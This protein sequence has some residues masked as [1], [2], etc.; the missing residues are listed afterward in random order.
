M[1]IEMVLNDLSVP[2]PMQDRAAAR[3]L[4]HKLIDVLSEAGRSGLNV[5][6]TKEALYPVELSPEYPIS[7]WLNDSEVEREKRSFL[8]SLVTKTP[9]L[10]EITD[11]SIQDQDI[12]AEF[13]YEGERAYGLGIAYL[14]NALAVSFAS[15]PKWNCNRLEITCDELDSE[16]SAL[17]EILTS[18]KTLIHASCR[19]HVLSHKDLFQDRLRTF[20]WS[21][22]DDLLPC[23]IA[24]DQKTPLVEWLDSLSA[25]TKQ[26]IQARL[27]QVK[28]GSLGDHK[29]VGEGVHE[30]RIFYGPGYRVY[31]G[32]ITQDK[33]L[34]LCGG[35]KKSQTE[36]IRR[37]K[38]YWQDYTQQQ[39]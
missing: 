10:E 33:K 8:R 35:D 14:L 12:L 19:D 29:P 18:N 7:R 24:V 2:E 20:S 30:L 13:F 36:D 34:L 21:P 16:S 1:P 25:Q 6:R 9:L 32:Y 15:D 3:E 22:Q 4:M 26:I 27:D 5:L 39:T 17:L 37:A 11:Q 38:G 31:F 23:Y 28:R